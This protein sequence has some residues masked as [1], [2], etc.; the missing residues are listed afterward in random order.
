MKT[1][2]NIE[3]ENPR[4]LNKRGIARRYGVST[5]TIQQWMGNGTITFYKLGYLVR[6]DPA[7]C[8]SALA[9]FKVPAQNMVS[10]RGQII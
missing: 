7:E 8:D 6:F 5:R 4:L 2:N 1:E 10:E 3:K 9:R